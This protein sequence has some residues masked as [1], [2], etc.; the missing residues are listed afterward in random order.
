[1]SKGITINAVLEDMSAKIQAEL[2][3][4]PLRV[5]NLSDFTDSPESDSRLMDTDGFVGVVYSGMASNSSVGS[6]VSTL[7]RFSLLVAFRNDRGRVSELDDPV[8]MLTFLSKV[9]KAL[10]KTHA[11]NGQKYKFVSEVPADFD[12]KGDGF[13]QQWTVPLTIDA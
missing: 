8:D 11:P 3:S 9:R 2:G 5:Y 10:A 6:G 4:S 1:M 12:V 13:A 7:G